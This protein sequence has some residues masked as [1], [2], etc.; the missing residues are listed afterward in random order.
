MFL[1]TTSRWMADYAWECCPC[2][3]LAEL[4]ALAVPYRTI[5]DVHIEGLCGQAHSTIV[6]PVACLE[7]SS[8]AFVPGDH[9]EVCHT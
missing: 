8:R 5:L 3:E 1:H 9:T 4:A 6:A 7:S 2:A